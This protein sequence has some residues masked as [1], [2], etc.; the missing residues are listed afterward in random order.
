ML[1]FDILDL[2]IFLNIWYDWNYSKSLLFFIEELRLQSDQSS[3]VVAEVEQLKEQMKSLKSELEEA[4]SQVTIAQC[5]AENSVAVERRKCQE[6]I[7]TLQQ[8]M[9][10]S[11]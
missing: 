5:T 7:A 8:L 1:F 10:G 2:T 11:I 9:K 4:K 3:A 6:E